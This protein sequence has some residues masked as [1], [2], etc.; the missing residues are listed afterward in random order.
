MLYLFKM[1]QP[2]TTHQAALGIGRKFTNEELSEYLQRTSG[3]KPKT[4]LKVKAS[5]KRR[6]KSRKNPNTPN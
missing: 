5:L 6:L 1:N 2:L 3:G 4:S